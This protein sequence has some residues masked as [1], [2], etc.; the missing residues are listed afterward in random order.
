MRGP[1]EASQFM[2]D[3][4]G[5]HQFELL[6]GE[7]LNRNPNAPIISIVPDGPRT[8]I[9]IGNNAPDDMMCF[10]TLSGKATLQKLA[11]AILSS[12]NK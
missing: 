8:Y 11:Q 6:A 5:N 12:V 3:E 7:K 4:N 10:A 9:W 2:K 1:E